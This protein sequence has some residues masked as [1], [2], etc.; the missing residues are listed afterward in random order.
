[1][2]R[3]I[4]AIKLRQAEPENITFSKN[5][6]MSLES[7]LDQPKK[8]KKLMNFRAG[9]EANI[10]FLKR[11]FGFDRVLDRTIETFKAALRCA[12]AAYNITLLARINLRAAKT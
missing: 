12:V 7:L 2:H 10:S 1:M 11:V 3:R 4:I 8:H 6:K 9:I 5:L